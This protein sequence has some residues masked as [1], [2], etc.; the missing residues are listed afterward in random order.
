LT[1]S[2]KQFSSPQLLKRKYNFY[3]NYIKIYLL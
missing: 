1:H 2:L 3:L